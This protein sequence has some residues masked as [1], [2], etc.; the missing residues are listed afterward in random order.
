[1]HTLLLILSLFWNTPSNGLQ[2]LGGDTPWFTDFEKSKEEAGQKNKVILM[3]FSGSDWCKP[4]IRL[5]QKV[6]QD[7]SFRNYAGEHLVLLKVDFPRKKENRLTDVQRRQN[8]ALAEKYNRTGAF[9]F[10]LLLDATGDVVCM[11]NNPPMDPAEFMKIIDE[12]IHH[13]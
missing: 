2:V 5:D 3:V 1:M 6:F 8:E 9:P 10:V 7:E 12:N 4:C 13:T 11:I